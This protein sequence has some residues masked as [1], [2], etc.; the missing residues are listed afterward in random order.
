MS[1][2]NNLIEQVALKEKLVKVQLKTDPAFSNLGVISKFQGYIGYILRENSTLSKVY[3]EQIGTVVIVPNGMIEPVQN[4]LSKVDLF[5]LAALR[6]LKEKRDIKQTDILTKLI[7]NCNSIEYVESFCLD[8]G[9]TQDDIINIYKLA[10]TS[11]IN[12]AV[13]PIDSTNIQNTGLNI[14]E[15]LERLFNN[16][17]VAASETF[18]NAA[19]KLPAIKSAINYQLQRLV[20]LNNNA[21]NYING[22]VSKLNPPPVPVIVTSITILGADT[23]DELK[24]AFEGN[25]SA[26]PPA[27][28]LLKFFETTLS[29]IESVTDTGKDTKKGSM[30]GRFAKG[31]GRFAKGAVK[32]AF[33][34]APNEPLIQGKNASSWENLKQ[35]L[36]NVGFLS[37]GPM[38][39]PSAIPTT[40]A[41]GLSQNIRI[42]RDKIRR[43]PA[44]GNMPATTKTI[45]M[46]S[47][48]IVNLNDR[49][50][51]QEYR[52]L[53]QAAQ[54]AASNK[55][56][57]SQLL[58][59]YFNAVS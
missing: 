25:P 1:A 50:T 26:T 17:G 45:N 44:K 8:N 55:I 57:N 22:N 3:L 2:F 29:E 6:Y 38:Q 9:C 42:L 12:E 14:L 49:S 43:D 24:V 11:T 51:S 27:E 37:A 36:R 10:F 40:P 32:L 34:R 18:I 48:E 28:G 58:A 33:G 19:T 53:F 15:T 31:A 20:D 52:N 46:V 16:N 39:S 30:L 5:K 56:T 59:C 47:D 41:A 21:A 23:L 35:P 54:T 4:K 13:A 7:I